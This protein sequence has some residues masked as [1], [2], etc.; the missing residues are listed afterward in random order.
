MVRHL[1]FAYRIQLYGLTSSMPHRE[2]ADWRDDMTA[3][4][5]VMV[6]ISKAYGHQQAASHLSHTGA[7]F[8]EVN[9]REAI[10][11]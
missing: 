5:G 7:S 11:A 8:A 4:N 10:F 1:D 9:F 6:K 2:Y 3:K